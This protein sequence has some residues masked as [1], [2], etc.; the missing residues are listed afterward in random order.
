L[1]GLV[2]GFGAQS[3]INDVVSGFFIL[4]EN[5]YLVGDVVEVGSAR[6]VVEAIEFRTTKIRDA[7]GRVHII[8]NGDMKPVIN[9]SKD[10]G[11]AVVA[12]EVPYDADLQRV[13]TRLRQAGERLRAEHRDVLAETRIEGITA[14]GA[15]TMTIRTATRVRPGQHEGVASTLRLLINE[16]FQHDA[17][18]AGRKALIGEGY[19]R[20]TARHA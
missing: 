4:F 2:I 13:L 6:G 17:G 18:V 1:L 19:A 11:V 20:R 5:I 15:S 10:Y 3:L 14:F 9:Y 12:I 8:R 16:T 7:E